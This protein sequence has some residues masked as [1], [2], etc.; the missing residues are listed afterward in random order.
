MRQDMKARITDQDMAYLQRFPD[1][2]R[3]AVLQRIMARK[4]AESVVLEGENDF[5]KT[6]LKLRR[7]G[8]GLIDLQRQDIAFTTV[9]Y[10]KGKALFG[11][12]GADVAMLLWEMQAPSASTTV[13]TWRF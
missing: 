12:A 8:Y 1:A 13:L 4:P 5:E 9:W 7:E 6:I 11:R 3:A 10:R 2:T